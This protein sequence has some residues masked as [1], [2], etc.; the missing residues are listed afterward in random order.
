MKHIGGGS[1]DAWN[2]RLLAT[3]LGYALPGGAD[4]TADA[5]EKIIGAV[6]ALMDMKPTDPTEGMLVA[7]MLAANSAAL[8]LYR[9]AWIPE[10]TFEART[11]FLALADKAAR[12]VGTLAESLTKYRTRGRQTVVVQHVNVG[13]GGQAVV[14]GEMSTRGG[15]HGGK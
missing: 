11:R 14:A 13:D 2:G 6:T 4:R 15:L 12:T 3:A 8:E 10:Q 5:D 7:Q 1:N 9:R